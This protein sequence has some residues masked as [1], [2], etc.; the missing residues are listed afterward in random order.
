MKCFRVLWASYIIYYWC[1]II[2]SY[3]SVL[4]YS[5]NNR[6]SSCEFQWLFIVFEET[7]QQLSTSRPNLKRH[8]EIP[9][10]GAQKQLTA[11]DII[12][13]LKIKVRGSQH[14][15]LVSTHEILTKRLSTLS[16]RNVV[17]SKTYTNWLVRPFSCSNLSAI[18]AVRSDVVRF[19]FGTVRDWS[20]SIRGGGPE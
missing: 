14:A 8:C 9:A 4:N 6:Q 16:V 12:I 11:T 10:W 18:D 2:F 7:H 1:E 13:Y 15:Q 19:L 3:N 5:S 17:M 20:I